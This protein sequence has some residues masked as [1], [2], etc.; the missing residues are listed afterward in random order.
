MPYLDLQSLA[1]LLNFKESSRSE[2]TQIIQ[3]FHIHFTCRKQ[4]GNHRCRLRLSIV[5]DKPGKPGRTTDSSI[6]MI[7]KLVYCYL[8]CCYKGGQSESSR[9][10][11]KAELN[12]RE[13]RRRR[14]T[15]IPRTGGKISLCSHEFPHLCKRNI[16]PFYFYLFNIRFPSM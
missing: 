1:R 13:P 5:P 7:R 8:W 6:P 12:K 11:A 2:S 16:D 4:E 10:K 3:V 9:V 14:S 15:L